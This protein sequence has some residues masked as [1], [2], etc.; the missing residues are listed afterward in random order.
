VP[1]KV[2]SYVLSFAKGHVGGR[3]HN[4]CTRRPRVFE[5][6]VDVVDRDMDILRHV[7]PAWRTK[8]TTLAPEHDGAFAY[9]KLRVPYHAIT[10]SAKALREAEHFAQPIDCLSDVL[11]NENG[12]DSRRW[13]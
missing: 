3:L 1:R 4:R 9:G 6:T 5:V 8:W 10:F 13:C 11:I 2:V 7:S 12:N